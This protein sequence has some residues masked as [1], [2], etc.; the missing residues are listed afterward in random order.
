MGRTNIEALRSEKSEM[1]LSTRIVAFD[2]TNL[3]KAG[4]MAEM[5]EALHMD[6][7]Q[8]LPLI[9]QKREM[10][11]FSSKQTHTGIWQLQAPEGE[12][13]DIVIGNA[14]GLHAALRPATIAFEVE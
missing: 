12:H 5:H 13:D 4:I 8:L 9:D 3:S 10:E 1:G 6:G 7:W 11:A 2:T 14:L